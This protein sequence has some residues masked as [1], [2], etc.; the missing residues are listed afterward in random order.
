MKKQFDTA[1]REEYKKNGYLIIKNFCSPEEIARMMDVALEDRH[2][3]SNALDL[4]DQEGKKTKLS[5]W[6]TPG[7]NPFGYLTRSEKVVHRIAQILDS[8]SPVCHSFE[9]H[10]K[11]TQGWRSMGVAS[12]LWVLV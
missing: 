7:K 4:N 1:Q 12:G 2:I 11:R 8:E 5:L 6:F 10:A 3:R 9:A